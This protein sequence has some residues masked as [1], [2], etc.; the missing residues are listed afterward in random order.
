M[1]GD[2]VGRA[3]T[4]DRRGKPIKNPRYMTQM[5]GVAVNGDVKCSRCGITASFSGEDEMAASSY[6]EEV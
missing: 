4:T 1:G 5:Y 2:H 3:V 6:D